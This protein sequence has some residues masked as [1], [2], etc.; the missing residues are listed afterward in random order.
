MAELRITARST[1]PGP[2]LRAWVS[3]GEGLGLGLSCG[4]QCGLLVW[5]GWFW[6]GLGFG[7]ARVLLGFC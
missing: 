3:A 5:V 1:G 6:L 4:F 2:V 7:V